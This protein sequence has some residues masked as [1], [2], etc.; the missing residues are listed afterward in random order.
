M[1]NHSNLSNDPIT[2]KKFHLFG[3]IKNVNS[4]IMLFQC[5]FIK[6]YNAVSMYV[7][8]AFYYLQ[9]SLSICIITFIY[10]RKIKKYIKYQYYF[11]IYY[12]YIYYIY[13]IMI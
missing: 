11:L 7:Y 13:Y 2:N 5:M 9:V 6:H 12:Y 8:K 1:K 10:Q 3:I 4:I